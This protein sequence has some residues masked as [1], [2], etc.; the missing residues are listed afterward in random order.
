MSE[1]IRTGYRTDED[2]VELVRLVGSACFEDQGSVRCIKLLK[3]AESQV[4]RVKPAEVS[5]E[6]HVFLSLVFYRTSV[7]RD[8]FCITAA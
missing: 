7:R 1:C 5:C 3:P 4:K 8:C 6:L 2:G